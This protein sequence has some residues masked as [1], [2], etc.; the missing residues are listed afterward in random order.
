MGILRIG[1]SLCV[2]L[3]L[4][5][6][7]APPVRAQSRSRQPR[8]AVDDERPPDRRR[9]RSQYRMTMAGSSAASHEPREFDHGEEEPGSTRVAR[10]DT[11]AAEH[12]SPGDRQRE[13]VDA[14][15]PNEESEA[16]S[17]WYR[18]SDDA[19]ESGEPREDFPRHPMRESEPDSEQLRQMLADADDQVPLYLVFEEMIDELVAE[20][21]DEPRVRISP[22]SVRRVRV[23]RQLSPWF[24][25]ETQAKIV[26]AIQQHTQITVRR[27]T[28]CE[29]LRS[30]VDGDHW[31]VTMGIADQA[32]LRREAETIG[33]N[34]FLDVRVA[35]YPQSNVATMVAEAIEATNG[36]VIWSRSFRSD[37]TTAEI[38]RSG[39][40]L[41]TRQERVEELERRIDMRPHLGHQVSLGAGLIPY[42]GAQGNIIGGMLGYRL[43]ERFGEDLRW[44][45]SF[46]GEGFLNAG[47]NALAGGFVNVQ[48]QY[49]LL[50]PS[51]H[52][53][54]LRTGLA[55]GGF[56]AGSEG[57]SFVAEWSADVVMQFL[58]GLGI[59]LFYFVPV[60]FGEGDL[61]GFGGKVRVSVNFF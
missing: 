48:M 19:G 35:Y 55:V 33:V 20:I 59:N 49:D 52:K 47:A 24:A 31:V 26:S 1:K 7:I 25:E 39:E 15:P 60:E 21:Q 40:E 6:L 43:V 44:S 17:P 5:T 18:R 14:S 13:G 54:Q 10:R 32:Q 51:L 50:P 23:S 57:N 41:Q 42:T 45:F 46:G 11:P 3:G 53:V 16:A 38:L 30:R 8:Q 37:A 58:L 56:I 9:L 36:T 12:R 4:A 28:T 61:G 2:C 27:C 29:S 34:A 22:L